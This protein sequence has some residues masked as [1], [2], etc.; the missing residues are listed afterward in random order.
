M[1]QEGWSAMV[2]RR[3]VVK[4]GE[5]IA[6]ASNNYGVPVFFQGPDDVE[7]IEKVVS[8]EPRWLHTMSNS[9]G[10]GFYASSRGPLPFALGQSPPDRYQVWRARKSLRFTGPR[11]TAA[12]ASP[13]DAEVTR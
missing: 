2:W 3:D 6:A 8:P 13:E 5:L 7:L 1:E 10:A 12:W 4:P 9:I 11:R